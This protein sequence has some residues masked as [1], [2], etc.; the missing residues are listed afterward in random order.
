MQTA[1]EDQGDGLVRALLTALLAARIL[2]GADFFVYIGTY[3]KT[4]Y[5]ARFDP[6]TGA[7]TKPVP[8]AETENP[9]FLAVHPSGKFLYAVNENR[10][11]RVSG[12]AIE[13]ET[14]ALTPL[15]SASTGGPGPCHLAL[16]ET[17]SSVL[18]ANYE[19]GSV[20]V[21]PVDA[22][23][24][25][26]AATAFIQHS[27]S[28][29]NRER[30]SKPHAHWVGLAPDHRLALVA[31]LG[32]DQVLLYRF[33][34]GRH[35]LTASNPPNV[36]IKPGS[37]PRHAAFQPSGR[38]V[39]LIAE[40]ASTITV[41]SFP[42]LA[43]LQTIK[44][45]PAGFSG[46]NTTA[47]IAVHPSGKFVYGSNRGNDSI[48]VFA[49][50][51]AQGTL[52]PVEYAPTRGKTPRNFEIDPEGHWLLAANQASNSIAVFRIDPA[53]GRLKASELMDGVPSPVCVKFVERKP[54]PR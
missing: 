47:E 46:D 19:G 10:D 1:N 16:D 29:V 41:L 38:F 23:G 35:S 18:V 30:Q 53:T 51:P 34:A 14:G 43:E 33:D 36:K 11:G 22:D 4:I 52:T 13:R 5:R 17:G 31:D 12:F 28:S 15:N 25:V 48:A 44:T 32:L 39:Y 20:A 9:S 40:L 42:A 37:G 8:A 21:L 49:V 7:I 2:A 54:P 3:G 24:R 26:G 6:A 27:G 45:L 50:D